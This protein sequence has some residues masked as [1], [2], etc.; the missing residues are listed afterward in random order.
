LDGISQEFERFFDFVL[1]QADFKLLFNTSPAK[2]KSDNNPS[3][4]GYGETSSS[5]DDEKELEISA[6]IDLEVTRRFLQLL[7]IDTDGRSKVEAGNGFWTNL[8]DGFKVLKFDLGFD[9]V[10]QLAKIF[11][12]LIFS[13]A[14]SIPKEPVFNWRM[15]KY[16]LTFPTLF[17]MF[18]LNH[19]DSAEDMI[20]QIPEIYSQFLDL[21]ASIKEISILFGKHSQIAIRASDNMNLIAG[22]LPNKN[23]I[24][25]LVKAAAE[26]HLKE[27]KVLMIGLDSS[28]KT[29]LLYKLKLGE[30]VTTVPTIG[31]NVETVNCPAA[32][33]AVTFWDVGGQ[34]RIRP[35]W[36][37]Y[38]ELQKAIIYVVDSNDSGRLEEAKKELWNVLRDVNFSI[39][40][41][42]LCNKQDL[43]N[44]MSLEQIKTGLD[45]YTLSSRWDA[46]PCCAITGDGLNEALTWIAANGH[47]SAFI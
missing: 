20:K 12:P 22:F 32:Q 10:K 16:K 3:S 8:V 13:D 11:Y 19:G 31:F 42:V 33:T 15:L 2:S 40:L 23:D 9:K 1:Q 44:A 21:T 47:D 29:T 35:L 34:D 7:A 26:S 4:G 39:P 5:G 30:V 37:H 17:K 28:G 14:E 45:L 46:I 25:E 18:G 36:K 43:P 38:Y 27:S 6:K 41:L 24:P